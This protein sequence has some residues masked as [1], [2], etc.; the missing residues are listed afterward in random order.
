[1]TQAGLTKKV[2]ALTGMTE[3]KPIEPP[4][5]N[6][7][8]G[9]NADGKPL[10]ETWSYPQVIGML[11]YLA[12]NTRPDIQFA[13]HQ[14][15]RF[16]HSPRASHGKAVKRIC[17]YLAGTLKG[18]IDFKPT[19]EL[20]LDCYCDADFAGLWGAEADQDPVCVKS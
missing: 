17:R 20:Q 6:Q 9:T 18:G 19:T 7:P 8:F 11:L 2:L 14:C 1:M 13:I 3:S 15:A 12:A 10:E 5:N 16:T 4:A